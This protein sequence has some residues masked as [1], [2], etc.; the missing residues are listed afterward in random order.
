MLA[1]GRS[2]ARRRRKARQ[3]GRRR[4][5]ESRAAKSAPAASQTGGTE[6][7]SDPHILI[8]MLDDAGYVRNPM[9][10]AAKSIRR[11]SRA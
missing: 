7:T 3:R 4:R 6:G 9:Q 1:A 8:I 5:Q 10:S 2:K 11:P